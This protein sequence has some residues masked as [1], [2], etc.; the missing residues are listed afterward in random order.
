MCMLRIRLPVSHTVVDAVAA[1]LSN[2]ETS[3]AFYQPL[4]LKRAHESLHEV[5][6]SN[7]Q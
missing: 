4:C 1:H 5:G 7:G 2:V 6:T 3:D